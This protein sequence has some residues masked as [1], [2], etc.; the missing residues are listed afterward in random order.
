[1][2][3]DQAKVEVIEKLPQVSVKGV[4]SFLRHVEFYERFNKDFLRMSIPMC[5]LLKNKVKF[6]F[7]GRMCQSI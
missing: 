3:V 4:Y 1:M 5:K 7:G 2:E 6:E